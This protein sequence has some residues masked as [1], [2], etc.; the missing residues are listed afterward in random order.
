MKITVVIPRLFE[1]SWESQLI[2]RFVVERCSAVTDA[3]TTEPEPV[4]LALCLAG[5]ALDQQFHER[6][7]NDISSGSENAEEILKIYNNVF[8]PTLDRFLDTDVPGIEDG[9][10]AYLVPDEYLCR[11]VLTYA[12]VEG[13]RMLSEKDFKFLG[14]FELLLRAALEPY[15]YRLGQFEHALDSFQDDPEQLIR[16]GIEVIGAILG[17]PDEVN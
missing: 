10:G 7:K 6:L 14:V 8:L 3:E 12:L 1:K 5:S 15:T 4:L 2:A 9:D 13:E 16:G 11:Q 17:S